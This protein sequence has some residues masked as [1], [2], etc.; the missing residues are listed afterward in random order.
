MT[1]PSGATE[2]AVKA[3]S[4]ENVQDDFVDPWN[5]ESTS[6][7][8]VDYDK[9]ISKIPKMCICIDDDILAL[10]FNRPI[11][12]LESG[13]RFDRAIRTNHRTPGSSLNPQRNL[14]LAS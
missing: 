2:A 13:Q 7:T 5:V 1:D 6:D 4:L 11:W 12:Q 9:L 8:G 3:L 10:P 14:L